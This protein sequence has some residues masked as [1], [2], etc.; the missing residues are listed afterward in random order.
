[1]TEADIK[2]GKELLQEEF[3]T[4][5]PGWVRELELMLK[6]KVK[7]EIQALSSFGFQA[8]GEQGRWIRLDKTGYQGR[9]GQG[10]LEETWL[11]AQISLAMGHL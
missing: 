1:M 6:M 4:K 7:A 11:L 10:G 8:C 2:A 3:I 9:C 5:N